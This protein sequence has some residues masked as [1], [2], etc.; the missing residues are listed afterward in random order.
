MPETW[1]TADT[2][3]SHLSIIA[4]CRRPFLK[5]GYSIDD[6][7]KLLKS[8]EGR[9][10]E[11][12]LVKEMVD[13]KGH[14]EALISNWNE[15]VKPNDI[16]YHLGDFAFRNHAIVA[17]RLNG[18]KRLVL[19]N[20]DK[21]I[22][23][24]K[25]HFD[26]IYKEGPLNEGVI[27]KRKKVILGHYPL[28]S[29]NAA[30]HGRLHFFGHV[31][32]SPYKRFLCVRNSYDVGVDNNN[33]KPINFDEAVEKAENNKNIIDFT[34]KAENFNNAENSESL[35]DNEFNLIEFD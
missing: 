11:Q 14:D 18:K 2:H 26:K 8:F 12:S 23:S 20:H 13:I 19:G 9:R 33:F 27:I 6:L 29:W 28:L 35:E 10:P 1:L 16:V 3:F 34:P 31:H 4:Y 25:L 17:N 22:N 21:R 7:T 15:L 24:Y 30:F 32:T 5:P